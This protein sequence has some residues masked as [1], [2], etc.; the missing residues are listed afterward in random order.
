MACPCARNQITQRL[1]GERARI[2][3]GALQREPRCRR[4]PAF[5][6][7]QRAQRS[8]Q[9]KCLAERAKR[10]NRI[11]RAHRS[12]QGSHGFRDMI[13]IIGESM[14]QHDGMRLSM[15]QPERSAQR[16]AELVMQRH[17]GRCQHHA[18]Q[19]RAIKRLSTRIAI[20][21]AGLDLRSG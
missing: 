3:I 10:G 5:R 18:R 15:R 16:V 21:R 11:V 7:A 2:P 8:G 19:P 14:R 9:G 6:H 1:F 20:S 17:A 13:G 12:A 4:N